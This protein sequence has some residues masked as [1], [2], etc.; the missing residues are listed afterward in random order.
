MHQSEISPEQA[1]R[2]LQ[3]GNTRYVSG[4]LTHPNIGQDRRSLTSSQG[5]KPFAA[6]LACADSR[7]PVELLLDQGIGDLFVVR[8]AGNTFGPSELGSTEYSVDH[9]GVSALVVFGHT[10]CGA[11]KAVYQDGILNGNLREISERILPAVEAA[12]KANPGLSEDDGVDAAAKENVWNA[13]E[14]ALSSSEIIKKKV[15]EHDLKVIGAF[16]DILTGEV[17][18][19]GSHPRE[20]AILG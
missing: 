2:M 18:W 15:K 12:K 9:L 3:E 17:E 4:N 5:Q 7:T 11:V 20:A 10:K 19:M 14:T 1:V 13:I 16:Y 6:L 8:V